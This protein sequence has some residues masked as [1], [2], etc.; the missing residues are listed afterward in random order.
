MV[1]PGNAPVP[2]ASFGLPP[3]RTFSTDHPG[4][5]SA[6]PEA[7]ASTRDG[8]APR[9]F[10]A[11]VFLIITLFTSAHAETLR[12][13][14]LPSIPDREGFAAPFAGVSRGALIVAGGANIAGDKWQEPLTK[15]WSDSVFVLEKPD[16]KWR[17]GFKLPRPLGY[18]VAVT[19]DDAVLCFGGS[20][21]AKHYADSFRLSWKN[22][23]IK[24]KP[25]PPLPQPCANACG[26]LVGRTVYIAGGI[27][28]PTATTALHTFWALDLDAP[29]PIWHELEPWPGPERMLA[30]AGGDDRSFYLF[31]GTKL[32]AGPD[33]KP[34]REYLRDAYRFTPGEG[35]TRLADLPRAAVA[36]PSPAIALL[37]S[38]L[39]VITGDDGLNVAFQ[40]VDQHPGFPRNA[41]RYDIRSNAWTVLDAVPFSR[42]TVPT[43]PW[44]GRVVVPNGEAR[45]RVR[46]PEVW[47]LSL[48]PTP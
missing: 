40:P 25:L 45:P 2:G 24:T 9:R 43:V 29:E 34:V 37:P 6:W 3:K 47:S 4:K 32:T 21:S 11:T 12:W 30:V 35:W 33:G 23:A 16:G 38:V 1:S 7:A 39:L 46:T 26:A 13:E 36:A 44:R 19:A 48:P 18:G 17:A 41:L 14:K 28:T 31:S 42:A 8:R 5:S 10:G 20:D 27:E 15:K 22:G